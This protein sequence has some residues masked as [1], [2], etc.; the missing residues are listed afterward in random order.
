MDR[1]ICNLQE[2]TIWGFI[3]GVGCW[4]LGVRSITR[5]TYIA[6]SRRFLHSFFFFLIQEESVL[7]VFTQFARSVAEMDEQSSQQLLEA[8]TDFANYPGYSLSLSSAFQYNNPHSFSLISFFRFSQWWFRF[9][10]S[11]SLPSS[12]H[13]QVTSILLLFLYFFNSIHSHRT[14]S[15]Q[16]HHASFIYA[17]IV[18]RVLFN[19]V[20]D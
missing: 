14:T 12:T 19:A 20:V 9:R 2:F 10:F 17:F 8:A 3:T 1:V 7:L 13:Y 15:I 18:I 5:R 11:Q 6:T 4:D 16:F